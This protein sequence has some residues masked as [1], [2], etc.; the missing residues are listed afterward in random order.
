MTDVSSYTLESLWQEGELVL[1]RGR[2][3]TEPSHI[4]VVAPLSKRPSEG[5]LRRLEH[6]YG[7]RSRLDPAWAVV[8]LALVRDKGQTMLVLEDPGGQPLDLLFERPLEL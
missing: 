7:L 8:P 3:E 6:E 4:L 5:T 2:R 1:Y